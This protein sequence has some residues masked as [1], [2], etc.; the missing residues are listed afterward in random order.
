MSIE[1]LVCISGIVALF[2]IRWRDRKKIEN[3]MNAFFSA[4][5]DIYREDREK[6]SAAIALV[7]NKLTGKE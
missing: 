6:L 1:F 2:L 5:E 7:I 4:M 3:E